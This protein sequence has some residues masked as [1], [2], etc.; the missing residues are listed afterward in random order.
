MNIQTREQFHE[1]CQTRMHEM[2]VN[3][4]LSNVKIWLTDFILQLELNQSHQKVGMTNT[5]CNEN[6]I[7]VT[8]SFFFYLNNPIVLHCTQEHLEKF[9]FFV[10]GSTRLL[11]G[12]HIKVKISDSSAINAH[13]CF[14]QDYCNQSNTEEVLSGIDR[15]RTNLTLH[16]KLRVLKPFTIL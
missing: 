7:T 6:Q 15:S 11:P 5:P 9:L 3:P 16:S 13:T 1:E 14:K 10:T 2:Q 4:L 8:S 12:Q